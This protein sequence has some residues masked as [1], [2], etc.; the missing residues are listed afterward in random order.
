MADSFV[1]RGTGPDEFWISSYE[2]RGN[3]ILERLESYIIA[4]DVT[5]EDLSGAWAGV[6]VFDGGEPLATPAAGPGVFAF[7]GRRIR[8]A[9]V[10][11]VFPREQRAAVESVI[12]NRPV[13]KGDAMELLRITAAI[14]AV[15]RDVGAGDLPGEAGLD[16]EAISYT[17]GCYL[18]Q[19][20]MARLK[21]IGQ[22]R[23]RLLRVRGPAADLPQVLPAPLFAGERMVG[24]LRSVAQDAD[25][26]IGF[27][28][29]TLMHVSAGQPLSVAPGARPSLALVDAP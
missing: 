27:S 22:V 3:A 8:D 25:G 9:H 21:A 7:P 12:G 5:V 15:P 28:M 2:S 11:W 13:L 20:V 26:F 16:A 23:R 6:T 17:K 14:P 29:L 4:D 1:L 24:E 10:E 19:E 18:G